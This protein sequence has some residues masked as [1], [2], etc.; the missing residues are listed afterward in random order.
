M[1]R[2]TKRKGAGRCCPAWMTGYDE[3]LQP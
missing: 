3:V 1:Q 2:R